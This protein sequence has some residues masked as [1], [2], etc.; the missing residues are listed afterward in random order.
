MHKN[1][2]FWM[3]AQ[4]VMHFHWKRW[5]TCI[6]TWTS[7]HC[8]I[9]FQNYIFSP[10]KASWWRSVTLQILFYVDFFSSQTQSKSI[11]CI[12]NTDDFFVFLFYLFCFLNVFASL[13][14]YIL[15]VYLLMQYLSFVIECYGIDCQ[16]AKESISRLFAS[17]MFALRAHKIHTTFLSPGKFSLI[18]QKLMMIFNL[19]D[20]KETCRTR[21]CIYRFFQLKT[22]FVFFLLW[23]SDKKNRIWFI[24]SISQ[25]RMSFCFV[26][27]NDR[28][29][30]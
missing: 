4:S 21:V 26:W 12:R 17:F 28:M 19:C 27:H 1:I 29:Y 11:K 25:S 20:I 15:F 3:D 8:L 6:F 16:R 24:Q 23:I 9:C 13:L 14:K 30:I 22:K 5:F 18:F 7:K 10:Y 2:C